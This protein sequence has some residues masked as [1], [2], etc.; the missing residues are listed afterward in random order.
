MARDERAEGRA[1][2]LGATIAV[3][4]QAA[5]G[6]PS[7]QRPAEHA[8]RFPRGATT[9]Q[10]PGE[11]APR[12]MIQDDGEVAPAAGEAKIR[13]VAHPELVAPRDVHRSEEHTSELQS[14]FGISYAV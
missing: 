14:R 8:T 13:D 7:V 4:R 6:T 9:A 10:R 3:K 5:S 2:V 11:H 12:V 1:H